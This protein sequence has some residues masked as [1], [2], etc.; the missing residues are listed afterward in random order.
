MRDFTL[1][2]YDG[3]MWWKHTISVSGLEN[4]MIYVKVRN[5]NDLEFLY[6]LEKIGAIQ[7]EEYKEP[8]HP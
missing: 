8:I 6:H 7:L 1:Y 3:T 2:N 5:L 4:I